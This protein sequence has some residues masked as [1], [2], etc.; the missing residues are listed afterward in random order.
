MQNKQRWSLLILGAIVLLFLGLI[1]AWSIFRAPLN[2]IFPSWTVSELSMN[3]TISMI[4]FCLGGFLSGRL[5]KHVCPRVIILIASALLFTGFLSVSFLPTGNATKSLVMLYIFYGVFCGLGVG[6]GYN[7]VISTV[8]KWFLDKPGLASGTLM[9]G[10]GLGGIVLGSIINTV[11]E[12]YGVFLTFKIIAVAILLVLLA[13]SFIIK[14]PASNP[15]ASESNIKSRD[16]EKSNDLSP[17]QVVKTSAFWYCFVWAIMTASA[18]LIIINSAA[19]I[20]LSFGASAILGLVVSVFNGLGRLIFGLI[21]DKLGRSKTVLFN[22][23][24]LL[25]GGI[26]LT[27]AALFN[28]VALLVVG[29]LFVGLSYGG[30]PTILSAFML[31]SFG[32]KHHPANFSVINFHLIPAALF[33]PTISSLLFNLSDGSYTSAFIAIIV[34][35]V[36]GYITSLLMNKAA[37]RLEK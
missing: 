9:M 15:T 13:G 7:S 17:V 29:L 36:I 32:A 8:T 3:F 14:L 18:G 24:S 37:L 33:G 16:S 26:S 31:N 22:C 10:F 23:V 21:F 1:Y 19:T 27:I 35:A 2:A 25:F 5:Q 6:M 4:C 20:A 34:L 11:I 28:I 12:S 30:C